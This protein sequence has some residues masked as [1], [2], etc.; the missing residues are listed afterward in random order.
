M[1]LRITSIT[2]AAAALLT[3]SAAHAQ[4]IGCAC[5]GAFAVGDRVSALVDNPTGASGVLVGTVGTVICGTGPSGLPESVLVRW[6]GMTRGS[7]ANAQLCDCA[8]PAGGTSA[9]WFAACDEIALLPVRNSTQGTWHPTIA[10]GIAATVPGDVLELGATTFFE[11]D[12]VLSNKDITIRGQGPEQTIID[13]GG[14]VGRLFT[15]SAGDESVIEGLTLRNGLDQ[16]SPNGGGAAAVFG[17]ATR[18]TF[19]DCHF[20]ANDGGR[21]AY[22]A[23]GVDDGRLTL[24]HCL[25]HD[26]VTDSISQNAT[27][28]GVREGRV[29]AVNCVFADGYYGREAVWISSQLGPAFGTFVNCTF[30]DRGVE[31]HVV[32]FRGGTT[33]DIVGCVFGRARDSALRSS[34]GGTVN[35]SRSVFE[36][37]TGDNI[38]G[39]P[40]FVNARNGDFR[41]A[42]G[43]LGIDAADFDAYIAAGGGLT[44][45][46]GAFRYFDDPGIFNTGVGTTTQLDAGAHEFQGA[47]PPQTACPGDLDGDGDTDLG[48]FGIFAGDFGC[49]PAP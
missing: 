36:E 17:G 12:L 46:D 2:A 45:I 16:D 29:T 48:D 41:L 19:R 24:E 13:G 9:D 1:N 35:A 23:V 37:A 42:P 39:L 15:M 4:V 38:R 30:Y 32:A 49:V 11:R 3:A 21:G 20:I 14:S 10:D 6:D 43:S 33:I 5:D 26:N 18:V 8:A 47:S 34:Q 40:T 28:I 31:N 27:A 44:D 25:F 7:N 22:G